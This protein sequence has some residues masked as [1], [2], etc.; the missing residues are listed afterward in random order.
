MPALRS[1]LAFNILSST[2]GAILQPHPAPWLYCV[3]LI[4]SLSTLRSL[5]QFTSSYRDL[6]IGKGFEEM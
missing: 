3:S 2:S 1:L 5:R 4:F 6:D